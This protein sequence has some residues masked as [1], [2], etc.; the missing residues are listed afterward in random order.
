MSAK[1]HYIRR[2]FDEAAILSVAMKLAFESE[3]QFTE[4]EQATLAAMQRAH[5]QAG[6]TPAELGDWLALMEPNQIEGVV[7][8]TKGVLHEMEFVRLE[9]EDGDTV[10][11]SLF[12]ETNHEGYD[13]SF[14]DSDT[15]MVWDAQLK[16]TDS[17]AYIQDWIDT[18]PDGEILVT[19]ELAQAMG[20][21]SSGLNNTDLT[22]R[23][24]DVVDL[25]L[26]AKDSDAIWDYL[27]NL[28]VVSV[29]LVAWELWQRVQSGQ[30]SHSRFKWLLARATGLKAGKMALLSLAMS[31][32]GLNVVTGATLVTRLI[33]QGLSLK[34]NLAM[35]TPVADILG[36]R[37][38]IGDRQKLIFD[39]K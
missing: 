30:L 8:N 31:V 20:V 34:N 17:E 29:G 2:N 5:P 21:N 23:T 36:V 16:A 15:G 13:V 11:A 38:L 10:H 33:L 14:I 25:L 39:A 28:T 3:V 9:N 4:S 35:R 18:H 1:V 27:P 24:E 37:R 12:S 6:D 19:E 32:P 22:T 7:S 26:S